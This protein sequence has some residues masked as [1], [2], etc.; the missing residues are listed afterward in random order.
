M[1]PSYLNLYRSGELRDRIERARTLLNPCRLC[2]RKC[3]VDRTMGEEGLCRTGSNAR[4]A[5]YHAHIGEEPELVGHRGSGT[6]FFSSCSLLCSFCQNYDI[7]HSAGGVTVTP[8]QLAA[9]MLDLANRGCHNINFVTPTHMVPFILEALIPAIEHG[10]EVPLVYNSS[11]YDR[12]ETLRL[13]DGVID[14]YL[15]DFKFWNN[16]WGKQFCGVPDYRERASE[17][18]RE[19]HRQVRDLETDGRNIAIRGLMVRHLVMPNNVAGT[20]EIARFLVR[21]ISPATYVNVMSQ[22]HPCGEAIDDPVIGRPL[23]AGELSEALGAA[24]EAGLR[25]V[26]D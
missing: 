13:L 10:L 6:I 9:L 25:R 23:R 5:S 22:Y 14:I 15:P 18:I 2:P 24:R 21:E 19:M 8:D 17:A 1:R 16:R 7:S 3:G 26:V 4:V 20:A 12:V 11:G